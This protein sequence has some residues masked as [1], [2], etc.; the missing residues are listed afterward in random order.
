MTV[1]ESRKWFSID[2]ICVSSLFVFFSS[3]F[4]TVKTKFTP[5]I[6]KETFWGKSEKVIIFFK[7]IEKTV[8]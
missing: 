1:L 5:F 7:K 3:N 4:M 2:K 8:F 6:K